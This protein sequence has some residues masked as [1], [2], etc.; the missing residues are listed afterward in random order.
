MKNAVR[1]GAKDS[2]SWIN[3]DAHV[4]CGFMRGDDEKLARFLFGVFDGHGRYGHEISQLIKERLPTTLAMQSNLISNPKVALEK[5]IVQVDH[6]VFNAKGTAVEYS[7]STCV[8]VVVDMNAKKLHV[9][10]VGDSRAVLGRKNWDGSWSAVPLTSDQK[11]ENPEEKERIEMHGGTV[12][13]TRING[14]YEGPDRVWDG[15][16]LEKP[17][18]AC[19][20]SLGDG[21]A[22]TLGVIPNPVVKS[23]P[24]QDEDKFLLVCSDG[25]WDAIENQDAINLAGTVLHLPL[26]VALAKIMNTVKDEEGGTLVD[27]TTINI[28]VLQ[29]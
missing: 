2:P 17:G 16:A 11:P 23:Y 28:V 7:G 3:Q 22:R 8:I 15:P 25:V 12:A 27:D 26:N 19:S 29:K 14:A 1:S 9:A 21:L 4:S 18:L 13:P 20:R 5:A 10:N 24:I 6:D